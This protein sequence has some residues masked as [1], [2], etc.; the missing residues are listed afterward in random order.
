MLVNHKTIQRLMGKLGLKSL[1]RI[2]KYR[3]YRGGMGRTAPDLLQRKFEAHCAN[4]KWVTDVTE[5][6][7]AGEKPYLS[8]VLDLYNGEII[9][10][11]TAKRPVFEMVNHHFYSPACFQRWSTENPDLK[12][13]ETWASYK[14]TAKNLLHDFNKD[15]DCRDHKLKKGSLSRLFL[16]RDTAVGLNSDFLFL[17]SLDRNG[18]YQ[19]NNSF[20]TAS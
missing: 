13:K 2:K 7:V 1:V 18:L 12:I 8:P 17:G 20:R 16:Q 5:F 10:F 9:A 19:Q 14:F 11:E 6:N 3:S 4:Q 15:D